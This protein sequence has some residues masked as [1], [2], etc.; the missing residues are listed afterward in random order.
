LV[1]PAMTRLGCGRFVEKASSARH[2]GRTELQVLLNFL[3]AGDTLGL[4]ALTI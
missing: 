2:D 3:R 4:A 1:V